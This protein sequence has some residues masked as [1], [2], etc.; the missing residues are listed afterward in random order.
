MANNFIDLFR[1]GFARIATFG[2]SAAGEQANV[3]IE[4]G[5]ES[6][7]NR[8]LNVKGSALIEGN[9]E[10]NGNFSFNGT[11]DQKNI[12]NL[13]VSDR[14]IR[15]NVGGTTA[16]AA[17]GGVYVEGDTGA[18]VGAVKFDNSKSSKFTM[19]NGADQNEVVVSGNSPIVLGQVLTANGP[20]AVP[21]FQTPAVATVIF[22]RLQT[23]QDGVQDGTNRVFVLANPIAGGTDMIF[24]NGVKVKFGATS[25]YVINGALNQI[26]FNVSSPNIPRSTD[27]F[28][29][30][31]VN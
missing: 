26:T 15:V 16:G 14:E 18:V 29:I 6:V 27:N 19:G 20:N 31:G 4:N 24:V 7:S 28:E 23:I 5:T 1:Q 2:S 9:L 8:V 22:N 13:E 21:T 3:T 12:N 30:W 17:G 10:I 11:I 25:D